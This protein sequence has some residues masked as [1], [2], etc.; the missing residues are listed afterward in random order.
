[1]PSI[2]CLHTAFPL[3][4]VKFDSYQIFEN[5][6]SRGR[7][8]AV[9]DHDVDIDG[10]EESAQEICHS[11]RYVCRDI[12]VKCIDNYLWFVI[13]LA[14][15]FTFFSDRTITSFGVPSG[16]WLKESSEVP[17]TCVSSVV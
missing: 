4:G 7:Y 10:P 14:F 9:W 1:M 12:P 16:S 15:F 6:I 11:D 3:K 13:R 5:T 2:S 17:G 8:H